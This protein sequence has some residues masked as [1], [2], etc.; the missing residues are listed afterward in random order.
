MPFPNCEPSSRYQGAKSAVS[1]RSWLFG[2]RSHQ[3]NHPS[4]AWSVRSL[5]AHWPA[6]TC[7]FVAARPLLTGFQTR[8]ALVAKTKNN[9]WLACLLQTAV[10]DSSEG[11]PAY[12][13][14]CRFFEQELNLHVPREMREVPVL[15]VVSLSPLNQTLDGYLTYIYT[16]ESPASRGHLCSK[17]RWETFSVCV[18]PR[19]SPP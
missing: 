3:P 6:G 13:D 18:W 15:V 7:C 4:I 5:L 19:A 1:P 8:P 14:V 9:A 11:A 10:V 16:Y 2:L 17:R 12:Q